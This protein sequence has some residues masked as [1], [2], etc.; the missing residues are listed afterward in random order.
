[1]VLTTTYWRRL[2]KTVFSEK[3]SQGIFEGFV[4]SE[5]V[6]LMHKLLESYDCLLKDFLEQE[7]RDKM[8]YKDHLFKVKGSLEIKCLLNCAMVLM[9]SQSALQSVSQI[10]EDCL[11]DSPSMQQYVKMY[12]VAQ[13]GV[14][15][16][17]RACDLQR[18]NLLLMEVVVSLLLSLTFEG[19]HLS[20]F[21]VQ[22]SSECN[23]VILLVVFQCLIAQEERVTDTSILLQKMSAYR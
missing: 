9:N 12:F 7:G 11:V 8:N 21:M 17:L 5:L 15:V 18:D 10:S 23:I 20:P 16:I 14:D 13:R 1:M 2:K 4:Q 19:Q 22:V 3:P 6:K